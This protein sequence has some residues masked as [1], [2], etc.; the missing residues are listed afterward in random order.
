MR[1]SWPKHPP[2][3]HHTE[4]TDSNMW[5]CGGHDAQTIAKEVE[6]DWATWATDSRLAVF[7]S[8]RGM[9]ATG[10]VNSGWWCVAC[11]GSLSGPHYIYSFLNNGT[12]DF[13]S[14]TW[15]SEPIL[16]NGIWVAS[17]R[18][19]SIPGIRCFFLFNLIQFSFPG[20]SF[21]RIGQVLPPFLSFCC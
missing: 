20:S 5:I 1:S 11:L 3:N 21:K 9:K 19:T 10:R 15:L 18:I 17:P 6:R 13:E 2:I 4:C 8:A 14:G 12:L 16:T 7:P